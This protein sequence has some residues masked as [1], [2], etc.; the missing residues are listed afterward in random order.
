MLLEPYTVYYSERP[1]Q[2]LAVRNHLIVQFSVDLELKNGLIAY[3]VKA[4]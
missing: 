4:F 1:I 2:S 3:V